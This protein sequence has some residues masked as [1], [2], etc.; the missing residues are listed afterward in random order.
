MKRFVIVALVLVFVC[1]VS[2]ASDPA[3][4]FWISVDERTGLPTAGWEIYL[5]GNT[6]HGRILSVVGEPQDVKAFNCRDSYRGFPLQGRVSEMTVVGTP[7]MF[8]LTQDR[9]GV[10]SGGNII[11]PDDGNMYRCRIVF[12]PQDGN[13]YRVDTLQVRGEIGLGIGRNQF[14]RRSTREAASALR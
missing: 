4:G 5:V 2:L 10:W 1:G 7:W 9:A 8:G 11:N 12:H 3:L 14:W 6:L 13:R